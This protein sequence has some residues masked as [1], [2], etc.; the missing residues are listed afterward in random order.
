LLSPLAL[1]VP[2]FACHFPFV[3]PL[4]LVNSYYCVFLSRR[5]VTWCHSN[6]EPACILILT[7]HLWFHSFFLQLLIQT[8][9]SVP[10]PTDPSLSL[11]LLQSFS[12]GLCLI[13]L[14]LFSGIPGSLC[15]GL[16]FFLCL[17]SWLFNI[18]CKPRLLF[19]S[20]GLKHYG[21]RGFQIPC[22]GKMNSPER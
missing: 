11:P 2:L 9:P 13:S 15:I 16:H 18:S 1:A 14:A 3:F 8:I 21:I 22:M 20:L 17:P 4:S 12:V 19:H 7:M 6:S 5:D 10:V